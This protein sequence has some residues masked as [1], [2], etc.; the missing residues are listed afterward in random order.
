[1]RV[2]K[3]AFCLIHASV[4]LMTKTEEIAF[5]LPP[6]SGRVTNFL[7]HFH[8]QLPDPALTDFSLHT[9]AF[10]LTS[11]C[12]LPLSHY[13]IHL[14]N[15]ALDLYI[16]TLGMSKPHSIP[17]NRGAVDNIQQLMPNIVAV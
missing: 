8:Q 10:H 12:I 15:L 6:Q 13:R 16:A 17:I 14:K 1:M 2:L 3:E 7:N 5:K 11:V 4:L 9:N